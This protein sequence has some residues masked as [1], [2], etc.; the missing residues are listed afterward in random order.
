[1]YP[2]LAE[3]DLI[4]A[5]FYYCAITTILFSKLHAFAVRRMGNVLS[6]HLNERDHKKGCYFWRWYGG[7]GYRCC[8]SHIILSRLEACNPHRSV[9]M[10]VLFENTVDS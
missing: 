8:I 3:N 9:S 1:V 5:L 2:Y 7:D 10:E 6:S 4:K